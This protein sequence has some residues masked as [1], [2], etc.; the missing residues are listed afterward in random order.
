MT[1]NAVM[2][3]SLVI[4]TGIGRLMWWVGLGLVLLPIGRTSR[5]DWALVRFILMCVA[6]SAALQ[7]SLGWL[8]GAPLAGR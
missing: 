2:V 3:T 7:L 1:G 8:L 5:R 6:I 4:G